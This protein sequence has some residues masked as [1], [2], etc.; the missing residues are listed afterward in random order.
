MIIWL[1]LL[2]SIII[3]FYH[4]ITIDLQ[5][6]HVPVVYSHGSSINYPYQ[7]MADYGFLVIRV[8]TRGLFVLMR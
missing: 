7:Q 2:Y 3:L 5:Y 6:S 1:T 4:F 8:P